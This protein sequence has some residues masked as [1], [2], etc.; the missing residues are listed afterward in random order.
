MTADSINTASH[1]GG[2]FSE[3]WLTLREPADH[4]ARNTT[5]DESLVHWSRQHQSLQIVE[6]GAGTGSNLR[7]LMPL[8]GHQQ[9][10]RLVDNDAALLNH[11]PSLLK[12]W[13]KEH[14]AVLIATDGLLTVE[15]DT[16]SAKV[17]T[18]VIDLANDLE[19]LSLSGVHLLTASALLDLTSETWLATLADS[20]VQNACACLFVLNYNGKIQ[21]QPELPSDAAVTNLLNQHQLGNKGFGPAM[22]PG[23][24][25]YIAQALENTGRAVQ[26]ADSDWT[27]EASSK[28]LQYAIIEGWAPAAK[29]Q[30]GTASVLIDQWHEARQQHIKDGLS[31]LF[32]GHIDVLSLP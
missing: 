16:F 5:L 17:T 23:A 11:L 12:A 3:S 4:Q 19:K 27:I 6:L 10:W 28:L 20:A 31:Q 9:H 29:E 8:L 13:A 32:V 22:G 1:A 15:H 14:G 30:D 2:G 25:L 18:E 21:W 26:M 7:Y 24:G